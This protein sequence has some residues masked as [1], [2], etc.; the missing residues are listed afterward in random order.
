MLYFNGIRW[1]LQC[2]SQLRA[3]VCTC[4]DPRVLVL[5]GL[6]VSSRIGAGFVVAASADV[7][8]SRATPRARSSPSSRLTLCQHNRLY[9][10]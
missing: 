7:A 3:H 9:Q 8:A 6:V 2:L 10:S 1:N 5:H 4:F